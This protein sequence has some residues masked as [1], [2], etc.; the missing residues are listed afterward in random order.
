M[1]CFS[2]PAV[3]GK[4]QEGTM[5]GLVDLPLYINVTDHR[6]S[7]R[8]DLSSLWF[9][10]V[11]AGSASSSP[12]SLGFVLTPSLTS[13]RATSLRAPFSAKHTKRAHEAK[14]EGDQSRAP[15]PGSFRSRFSSR[16][17]CTCLKI[18]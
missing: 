13:H 6:Y 2:L 7:S 17:A 9:V 16:S 18:C 5:K 1:A 14:G 3:H 10:W 12:C 15:R 11:S 4:L 8:S